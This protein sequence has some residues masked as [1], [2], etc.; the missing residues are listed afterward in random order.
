[1]KNNH[2][3]NLNY[4]IFKKKIFLNKIIYNNICKNI[5]N[6]ELE[7]INYYNNLKKT[8]NYFNPFYG[9]KINTLL[10][11]IKKKPVKKKEFSKEV[12]LYRNFKE[13]QIP[14]KDLTYIFNMSIEKLRIILK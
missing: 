6:C 7:I 9:V 1:M 2:L 10:E 14:Y 8:L 4:Y 3:L 5:F 12:F 11:K 13:Y